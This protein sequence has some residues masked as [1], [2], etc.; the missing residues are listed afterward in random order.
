[1][2][3]IMDYE[4]KYRDLIEAVKELQEANPSDEGIQKWVED[5]VPQLAKSKDE[6][7][8]KYLIILLQHFCK[9]YRVP[10][11]EFPISF[12]D[13]LIWLENQGEKKSVEWSDEDEDILRTIISDG[14]IRADLDMQQIDWLKDLRDR[15]QPQ[16]T[17]KPS[18]EQIGALEHF[19]RSITESGFASP[20]DSN[21]K[22][23][24]SLLN[25]LKKN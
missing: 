15:V 23:V 12:K 24:Y 7:I 11:L 20:Y 22:L 25:D 8:R 4:K 18:D 13:M 2:E 9:G 19:V 16:T 1:M 3:V 17:W 6:K 10:G 5:N 21:T 14:I